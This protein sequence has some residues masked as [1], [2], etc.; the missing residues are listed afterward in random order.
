MLLKINFSVLN[1]LYLYLLSHVLYFTPDS[2]SENFCMDTN[3]GSTE[4]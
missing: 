2:I 1:Y 3:T 4:L